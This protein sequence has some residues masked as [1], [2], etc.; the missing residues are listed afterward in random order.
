MK[1]ARLARWAFRLFGYCFQPFDNQRG[2][3]PYTTIIAQGALSLAID[4]AG[5][6]GQVELHLVL[7]ATAPAVESCCGVGCAPNRNGRRA[8]E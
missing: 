2:I 8:D 5:S 6:A 1:N 7:G 4:R 3:D